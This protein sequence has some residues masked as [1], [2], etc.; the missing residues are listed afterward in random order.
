MYY[1]DE[2]SMENKYIAK[3][4][5]A[6]SD[7]SARVRVSSELE[8]HILDKADYFR[9]LGYDEQTAYEKATEEMGDAEDI[10]AALG[11]LHKSRST[12]C[13]VLTV[14]FVLIIAA[15][16]FFKGR[17]NY[18]ADYEMLV[19]HSIAMDF[20]SAAF[21]AVAAAILLISYR[22]KRKWYAAVTGGILLISFLVSLFVEFSEYNN[23]P[24][25]AF[26]P[27]AYAAAKIFTSGFDGYI[28]SVFAYNSV[29]GG[30]SAVYYQ[31]T[32]AVT[33][34]VLILWSAVQFVVLWRNEQ[35][36]N[37]RVP[38]KIIKTGGRIIAVIIAVNIVV[39]TFGTV[40]A[41][42]VYDKNQTL[43]A[44]E[45]S[46][47]IDEVINADLDNVPVEQWDTTY[48]TIESGKLP[49]EYYYAE[50]DSNF[51]MDIYGDK[52]YSGN[53]SNSLLV[54][55]ETDE[56][57][58][59]SFR[60]RNGDGWT[61]PKEQIISSPFPPEFETLSE[62]KQLG[63]YDKATQVMHYRYHTGETEE[64]HIQFWFLVEN[65]PKPITFLKHDD[66]EF[67]TEDYFIMFRNDGEAGELI[68]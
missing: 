26:Q 38:A 34:S 32:S 55:K 14:L 46:Q 21:I 52:N 11:A 62:F 49:E 58:F 59:L 18:G 20:L 31:I 23:S 3:A 15:V 35:M 25:Y 48:K 63:W 43:A 8:S 1:G 17:M 39:M 45:R 41:A 7:K 51:F 68:Q 54:Y 19:Y 42:F 65:Q 37:A 30:I 13:M 16:H 47:M 66:G 56:R 6:I 36:K 29:Q 50:A 9:E 2:K 44:E 4:C 28:N 33:F 60:I 40:S 12:V 27:V 24:L 22:K 64:E 53:Y 10:S 67:Y 61:I 5:E 57:T